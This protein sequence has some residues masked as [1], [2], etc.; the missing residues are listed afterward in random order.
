MHTIRAALAWD[1]END[2]NLDVSDESNDDDDDVGI[3]FQTSNCFDT[4]CVIN[5]S[6]HIRR[7]SPCK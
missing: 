2:D 7:K 6:L 1:V 5:G 4:G 3:A